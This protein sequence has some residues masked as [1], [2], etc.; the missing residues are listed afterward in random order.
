MAR[1]GV[2]T[3]AVATGILATLPSFAGGNAS[4]GK[5]TSLLYVAAV[6]LAFT[7]AT[8]VN[9]LNAMASMQC[10]DAGVAAAHPELAKGKALGRHRSAGQLGRAIGPIL[11]ESGVSFISAIQALITLMYISLRRLL[12]GWASDN[13]WSGCDCSGSL[14]REHEDGPRFDKETSTEDRL[15]EGKYHLYGIQ[16]L[17][18]IPTPLRRF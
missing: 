3:C 16:A 11:G 14:I 13:I 18:S 6:F 4:K 7:S 12:D 9:A 2:F 15:M 8:V 17:E 1:R 10:D 5:A